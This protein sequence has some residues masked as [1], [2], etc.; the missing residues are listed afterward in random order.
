MGTAIRGCWSWLWQGH[1]GSSGYT[2]PALV[3]KPFTW[4]EASWPIHSF[5]AISISLVFLP[6]WLSDPRNRLLFES[7]S[8]HLICPDFYATGYDFLWINRV[9]LPGNLTSRDF[10]R[11]RTQHRASAGSGINYI[12]WAC[13]GNPQLS[14]TCW[15]LNY[16]ECDMADVCGD[17][18]TLVGTPMSGNQLVLWK[19]DN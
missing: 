12:V 13:A 18:T 5:S 10:L 3:E 11:A 8:E 9:C 15:G 19:A 1:G 16:A 6:K 2:C 7:I 4:G 17:E 14:F